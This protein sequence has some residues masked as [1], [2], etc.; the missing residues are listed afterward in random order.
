M[1][2]LLSADL[3]I[4]FKA[5]LMTLAWSFIAWPVVSKIFRELPDKGWAMGRIIFTVGISLIV[6]NLAYLGIPMNTNTGVGVSVAVALVVSM[7]FSINRERLPKHDFRRTIKFI[8]LEEYL[9]IVGFGLMAI[10]RGFAPEIHSLEKFMDYGFIKRYLESPVLPTGD[11]WMAMK[12]INYYSFGHFW[13]SVLIRILGVTPAIGYNLVLAFIA[14]TGLSMSFMVVSN[15]TTGKDKA[16]IIGGLIGSMAVMVG[17]NFHALWYLLS[18]LGMNGYWYADAT[19]FIHNTIHEF[20]SYSF[21]VSDLHGHLLDLPMVLAFIGIYV[22]W[23]KQGKLIFEVLMGVLMGV[24]MMTNTW[25]LAVYG[26]LMIVF[27]ITV[28]FSGKIRFVKLTRAAFVMMIMITLT[29]GL[30]WVNFQSISN[31]VG[32]VKERTPLWQLA[33]LWTGGVIAGLL[34]L[35]TSIKGKQ[36]LTVLS[37]FIT[38]VLLIVIPELVYAK[39]IYPNHPRANTMFK[40]TYQAFIMMG[41][42]LGVAAGQAAGGWKKKPSIRLIVGFLSIIIFSGSMIFPVNGFTS[43]YANFKEY[44]GLDGEAW[45]AEEMPEKYQASMFLRKNSNGMNMVE[46]VG[47]SYSNFNAVS[48]FSGVP[49]ICGWRVHE[50]LWRG[51]YETVGLRDGEVKSIYEGKNKEEVMKILS[52]YRVGWVLIGSDERQKYQVNETVLLSLGKIAWT[53]KNTYLIKVEN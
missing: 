52:K 33:V 21:I 20:P 19:R 37:I 13:S 32:L 36:R 10:V 38:V 35:M 3:L 1:T 9:F 12:N 24:M 40:L 47:D 25:D 34:A 48:V 51:G 22:V 43:Y 46:A 7:V 4:I 41:L 14:G 16:G 11:M 18:H 23:V 44:K 15:L 53:D 17:G 27:A 29:A 30:W 31:G 50:W 49:T 5:Y 2:E 39:D 8:V 26:L 28:L 45:M 6:W 42:M